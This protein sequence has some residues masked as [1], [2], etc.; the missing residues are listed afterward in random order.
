[1]T[2]TAH[3]FELLTQFPCCNNMQPYR[4]RRLDKEQY[5]TN[6]KNCTGSHDNAVFEV[7][8]QIHSGPLIDTTYHQI[9]NGVRVQVDI[10]AVGS[11][12]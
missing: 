1:M 12:F 5:F 3:A 2:S 8:R 6:F 10:N 4:N 11:I 7:K 9:I